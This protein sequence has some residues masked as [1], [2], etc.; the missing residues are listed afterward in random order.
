[1]DMRWL[2]GNVEQNKILCM[3]CDA[4]RAQRGA[5]RKQ[6]TTR[7]TGGFVLPG[8]VKQRKHEGADVSFCDTVQSTGVLK[9]TIKFF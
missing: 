5:S 9:Q 7:K 2:I 4:P 3:K 1:M 6:T 8:R